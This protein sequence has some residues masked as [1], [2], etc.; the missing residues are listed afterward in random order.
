LLSAGRR[1]IRPDDAI[2]KPLVLGGT[3]CERSRIAAH[4]YPFQWLT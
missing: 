4:L 3:V 1:V 2:V